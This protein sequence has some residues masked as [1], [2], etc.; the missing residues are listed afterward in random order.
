M[1]PSENDVSGTRKY[2][3]TIGSAST[4]R[5]E[6]FYEISYRTGAT[7]RDSWIDIEG[8]L[9]TCSQMLPFGNYFPTNPIMEGDRLTFP[10]AD[11]LWHIILWCPTRRCRSYQCLQFPGLGNVGKVRRQLDGRRSGCC[12]T[13]DQ[14][15]ISEGSSEKSSR[16]EYCRKVLT[17]DK[18]FGT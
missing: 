1:S 7:R 11:G 12:K 18:W 6:Q 13:G 10:V 4:K 8:G 15:F 3:K 17:I 5:K 2:A 14:H 16:Q 9:E